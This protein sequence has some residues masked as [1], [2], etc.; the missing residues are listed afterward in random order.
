MWTVFSTI[1]LSCF[2][3]VPLPVEPHSR[4]PAYHCLNDRILSCLCLSRFTSTLLTLYQHLGA[5]L[6]GRKRPPH[7]PLPQALVILRVVLFPFL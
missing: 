3:G 4:S 6:I 1:L 7:N 2:R 5:F